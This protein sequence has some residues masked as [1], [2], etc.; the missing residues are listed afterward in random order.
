MDN[1]RRKD[2]IRAF[3][4]APKSQGVF[5]VRC[6]ASGEV[7]VSASR[8]LEKQQ[9]GLW[10]SLRMGGNHNKA[11]QAAWKAHGESA[12]SYEVLET[13]EIEDDTPAY[14]AQTRLKDREAHWRQALNAPRALG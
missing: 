11:M 12:F 2:L 10:F 5:A 9:T 8:N 13:L 6:A 3:K 7:W 1:A 4:E 14:V